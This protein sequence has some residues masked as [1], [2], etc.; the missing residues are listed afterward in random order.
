MIVWFCSARGSRISRPS[1]EH[2][3]TNETAANTTMRWTIDGRLGRTLVEVLKVTP[4]R[5]AQR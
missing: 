2:A 5:Y 3:V 1:S 4:T